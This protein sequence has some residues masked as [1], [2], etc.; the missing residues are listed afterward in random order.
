MAVA[1]VKLFGKWT[2]DDVEVCCFIE[3]QRLHIQHL[4]K[5]AVT[6]AQSEHGNG[7]WDQQNFT[8]QPDA[9]R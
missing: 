8:M 5:A 4:A 3:A 1:E 9:I 6:N 2:F 7:N